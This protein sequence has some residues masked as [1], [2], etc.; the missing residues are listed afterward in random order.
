MVFLGM[1]LS[2]KVFEV[3]TKSIL[4]KTSIEGCD[5]SL[6]QYVGC[7]HACLYCY[8]KYMCKYYNYGDWGSW[9]LVKMNA[10]NLIKGRYIDGII[11]M[12][13]V[14]DPYQP[15]EKR[16]MLTRKI[17]KYMDK[18]IK[19]R[20]LTKSDLILRDL[21][22]L[23]TYGNIEVGLTVN[24][25]NRSIKKILEP[26]SPAHNARVNALNEIHKE[27]IKTYGFISPVIPGLV[28]VESVINEVRGYAIRL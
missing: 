24:G 25:F 2:V 28:D 12:S 23:K 4:T 19:L 16:Y 9:V 6:N 10:P 13:T 3:N 20:I 21:D 27:G 17:L 5:Y 26:H 22:I 7:Q 11:C 15:I 18:R 1:V 8:A 14:S